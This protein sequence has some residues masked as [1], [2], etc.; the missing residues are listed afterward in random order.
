MPAD[1]L[2][3]VRF[4]SECPH[5]SRLPAAETHGADHGSMFETITTSVGIKNIIPKSAACFNSLATA[6]ES[7]DEQASIRPKF[8]Q[9]LVLLLS[10]LNDADLG[11]VASFLEKTY[12]IKA[13]RKH[14]EI[15][16]LKV[17]PLQSINKSIFV[18]EVVNAVE[19]RPQWMPDNEEKIWNGFIAQLLR[20]G[21]VLPGFTQQMGQHDRSWVVKFPDREGFKDLRFQELT[22]Y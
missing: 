11:G 1:L 18:R 22:V 3:A 21:Y 14:V 5:D 8:L 13:G 6:G 16:I 9:M 7:N 15:L 20:D 12:R 19:T 2:F 4:S 17:L 10:L